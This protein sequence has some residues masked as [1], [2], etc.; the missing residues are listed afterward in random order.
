MDSVTPLHTIPR[1]PV[2]LPPPSAGIPST[3]PPSFATYPPSVYPP[4]IYSRRARVQPYAPEPGPDSLPGPPHQAVSHVLPPVT[5]ALGH[6]AGSPFPIQSLQR[7]IP[8][9][10]AWYTA[11]IIIRSLVLLC[12]VALAS[13]AIVG[14]LKYSDYYLQSVILSLPVCVITIVYD[15]AELVVF[16]VRRRLRR[17]MHPGVTV[18]GD[19]VAWILPACA[20]GLNAA[21][22]DIWWRNGVSIAAEV[23]FGVLL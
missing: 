2:P 3:R 20:L 6:P 10:P 16:C 15:I 17:G 4:S 14:F 8:H 21:G 13:T 7:I 1:R 9:S 19:L 11:K 5:P 22:Y 18:G 12:G 23:L